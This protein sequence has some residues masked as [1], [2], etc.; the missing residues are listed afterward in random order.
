MCF[1]CGFCF[2]QDVL[3]RLPCRMTRVTERHCI[4]CRC[5]SCCRMKSDGMISCFRRGIDCCGSTYFPCP[6]LCADRWI[7]IVQSIVC[8]A[9]SYSLPPQMSKYP[10]CVPVSFLWSLRS[11]ASAEV[12]FCGQA[13][14]SCCVF[15]TCYMSTLSPLSI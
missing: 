6:S 2:S 15:G 5:V 12:C 11:C 3:A 14:F 10:V 8:T 1:C 9:V 13:F 4:R 7:F